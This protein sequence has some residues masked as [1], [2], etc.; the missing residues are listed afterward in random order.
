[1]ADLARQSVAVL[2]LVRQ[3]NYMCM[4]DISHACGCHPSNLPPER[5]LD[6]VIEFIETHPERV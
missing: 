1:M 6:K 3:D 4:V 5:M 2:D